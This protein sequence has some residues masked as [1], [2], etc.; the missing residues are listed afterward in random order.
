MDKKVSIAT[1]DRLKKL[2]EI[3]RLGIDPY[4]ASLNFERGPVSL[5]LDSLDKEAAV[6]GRILGWRGHGNVIFADVSDETGKMQIFFQKKILEDNFKL[7]KLV[8]IGDFLAVKGKVIKTVAGEISIDVNEFQILTKTIKQLPPTWHGLKDVEDRY[9]RRYLDTILNEDVKKRLLARSV[10]IDSVRDFLTGKGFIEVET[11]TLQPVYGGGFARPFSTHH[12]TLDTNFYLRISDEMYLKR[13]VVGGF[14]K[15]FEITKVFRNEGVDY[16]HNP[17]FTMFEAMIAY[18]D[19]RY[20]MD[21]IEDIFE[22]TAKRLLDKTTFDY[23][24]TLINVKRPWQRYRLVESVKKLTGIDP[25]EWKSLSDAKKAI[26]EMGI[27]EE[28]TKELNRI[29]SLGECMAFAF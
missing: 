11:P 6:A 3:R 18:K 2:E 28:K 14:E 21:L 13:M 25:L 17:E 1:E 8:D 7:L 9:R 27:P 16:D 5:A 4:P 24:G 20:G 22:Y 23:Q 10:I 19:Y 15:V 29:Q 26:L 12:N